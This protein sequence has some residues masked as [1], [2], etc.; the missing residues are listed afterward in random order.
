MWIWVQQHA[1]SNNHLGIL[2]FAASKPQAFLK[3]RWMMTLVLAA[4]VV[5]LLSSQWCNVISSPC[6]CCILMD[7]VTEESCAC[8]HIKVLQSD[9]ETCNVSCQRLA[10]ANVGYGLQ[11]FGLHPIWTTLWVPIVIWRMFLEWISL[12]RSQLSQNLLRVYPSVHTCP[13]GYP[14]VNSCFDKDVRIMGGDLL[15]A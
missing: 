1:G 8:G 15:Y 13:C 11:R 12:H 4:V 2:G 3:W 6:L 14:T 5:T 9:T 7:M 10:P